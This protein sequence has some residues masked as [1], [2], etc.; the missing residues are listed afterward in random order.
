MTKMKNMAWM[1][2][3][4]LKE[5]VLLKMKQH[6]VEDSIV[7]GKYQEFDPVL[8]SQY[9]GCLI[10]CT[11]PRRVTLNPDPVNY[12]ST[13]H[14]SV[15]RRY[16]IPIRLVYLLESIFEGLPEG[17]CADFAV[18]S[19]EA[20]PV[21]ANLNWVVEE[22][23]KFEGDADW[24]SYSQMEEELFKLLRSAPVPEPSY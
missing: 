23:D 15:R 1:G 5:Q 22:W 11:L 7:Q 17:R 6:R 10:G 20:I 4:G 24:V 19:I 2:D 8:A 12:H 14:E 18:E 3:P 9:R 21:G 16:G 13:W